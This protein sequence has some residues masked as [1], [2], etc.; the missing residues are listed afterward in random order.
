[1]PPDSRIREMPLCLPQRHLVFLTYA[2]GV[3]DRMLHLLQ[4]V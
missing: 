2:G 4:N 1:M 3:R